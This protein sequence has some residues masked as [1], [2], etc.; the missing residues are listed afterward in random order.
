MA[1]YIN[2][3]EA[4]AIGAKWAECKERSESR[5]DE[6]A[7]LRAELKESLMGGAQQ[8]ILARAAAMVLDDVVSELAAKKA[9]KPARSDE[10]LSTAS[11]RD[12]RREKFDKYI[13]A[14]TRKSPNRLHPDARAKA[15]SRL[16]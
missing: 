4:F 1:G 5:G 7:R 2:V 14:A 8:Q 6:L 12:G 9:G 16:R 15:A 10:Q 13:L 3:G 11:N